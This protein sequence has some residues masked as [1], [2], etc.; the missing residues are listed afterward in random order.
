MLTFEQ[1]SLIAE[2]KPIVRISDGK[3]TVEVEGTFE[4]I[5]MRLEEGFFETPAYYNYTFLK[6]QRTIIYNYSID[7]DHKTVRERIA[8]YNALPQALGAIPSLEHYIARASNMQE[9]EAQR[10]ADIKERYRNYLD[11]Y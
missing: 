7:K 3:H 2:G 5:C 4:E 8:A 11:T 9:A 6:R 10:A 1:L